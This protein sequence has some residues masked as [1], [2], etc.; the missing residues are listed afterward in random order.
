MAPQ[1]ASE[2]ILDGLLEDDV[3]SQGASAGGG[4]SGDDVAAPPSVS[5]HGGW[6]L[7]PAGGKKKKKKRKKPPKGEASV[8]PS[9]EPDEI[10]Y[11]WDEVPDSCGSCG[12][13]PY[14]FSVCGYAV[15]GYGLNDGEA[16]LCLMPD[17]GGIA[18]ELCQRCAMPGCGGGLCQRDE[19]PP[20]SAP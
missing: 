3:P 19:H 16:N 18:R 10:P 1:A 11:Y 20:V 17:C 12:S 13:T 14:I 9:A 2:N 15:C 6:G 8:V 4:D 7:P 5:G